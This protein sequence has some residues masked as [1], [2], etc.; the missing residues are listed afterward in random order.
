M[1]DIIPEIQERRARRGYSDTAVD[2]ETL[3][4]ILKA[5]TM[6]A[7]CSNKQP[8]RFLACTEGEAL[9]KARDAL[10][11]GNYWA[12]VAPVLLVVTTRDELD[13]QLN[14][15]RNYAQFDTGMA[16][17]GLLLQATREGLYAHPMAGF[18]PLKL[19]ES[20]GIEQETSVIAM[21]AIGHP[22]DGK[23]LNE[24][25]AASEVSERDRKEIDEVVQW[26]QWSSLG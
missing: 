4:R 5:G 19:R 2:R 26:N 22:G 12:K 23:N 6:A 3:E 9:E 11:G 17:A 15:D 8:W 7:S 16:V 13:C 10:L 25:H 24:K 18:D 14:D 1:A 21:I 20:F